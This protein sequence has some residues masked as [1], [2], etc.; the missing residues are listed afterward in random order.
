MSASV[1]QGQADDHVVLG[2]LTSPYGVKGWL[3]VYSYTSPMEGILEYGDWVLRHHG[4]LER[5][6]LAQ[7]RL[8]GKGLVARLEGVEDRSQAEALAGA[9]VLL[10]KAELP[11]LE[12]EDDYYWYQLEGLRV[13]TRDG[14]V[15][16]RIDYLFETGA[17]DVMVVKGRGEDAVD[18][19]E[20][21][22]PFLPGEVVQDVDLEAGEMTVDWDP[23][24]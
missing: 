15:L 20:R 22:L 19:R 6:R 2:K 21:L 16:G 13:V 24:F 9:E 10:P 18:D 23:D 11:E 17:N 1:E 4:R 12:G 7:G 3:K 5:H 8:H 14:V